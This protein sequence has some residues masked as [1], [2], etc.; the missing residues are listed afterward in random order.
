MGLGGYDFFLMILPD[1]LNPLCLLEL[2]GISAP[3]QRDTG[4]QCKARREKY[5]MRYNCAIQI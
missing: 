2:K 3:T 5:F 4:K 1:G